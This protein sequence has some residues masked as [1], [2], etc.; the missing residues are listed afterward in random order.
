MVPVREIVGPSA[1]R[2][3]ASRP[4]SGPTPGPARDNDDGA[5]RG[6]PGPH[7]VAFACAA[8]VIHR[9]FEPL[10][11]ALKQTIV[12]RAT[13]H[14]LANPGRSARTPYALVVRGFPHSLTHSQ[15][16]TP[17]PPRRT[18]L[19]LSVR[20]PRH[21]VASCRSRRPCL[22]SLRPSTSHPGA[23]GSAL[24]KEVAV[25]LVAESG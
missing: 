22:T 2:G 13:R 25:H 15:P 8:P 12:R 5:E 24:R 9:L 20:P 11:G 19:S 14:P 21:I 17:R 18:A 4:R 6:A 10:E 16:L 3:P 1:D 7:E 23:W